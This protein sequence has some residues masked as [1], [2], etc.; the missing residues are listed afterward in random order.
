MLLGLLV[1]GSAAAASAQELNWAQKLFE[2]QRHDF[3]VVARGADVV[4]PLKL[5]NSYQQTVHIANVRTSCGCI[6]ATASKDTLLSGDSAT[7]QVRVD[8]RRFS[9]EKNSN[10]I[11]TFDA[12]QYQE[13]T[14]PIHAYIRT[15]VVL[16]PGGAEFGS[17]ALGAGQ[18][19]HI[20]ISYAGR[21]D[22]TIKSVIC[23]NDNLAT[24]LTEVS[25]SEG[26]V[27]YDLLVAV[28]SSA[29][30]GDIRE[31]ILLLTDDQN[32]PE[33]PVLVEARVE[34]EFII[35]PNV[36]SLG[37]LAP[38]QKKTVQVVVRGRKPFDIAKIE[39]ETGSD[40]FKV[41][42]PDR[43][44]VVHVLPL[45]VTAPKESGPLNEEF[46]VTISGNPQPV[47]FKVNGR[48]VGGSDNGLEPAPAPAPG[49]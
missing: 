2:K 40:A 30:V 13:V 20:A 4:Y 27:N 28:K 23:K 39:S 16:T 33:I 12:P 34:P 42:L 26:R 15:D 6:S 18:E 45:I 31:Q 22:W 8:T 1:L 43:P 17:V 5:N 7:I 47:H 21:P 10:V 29:S 38:G 41:R 35:T 48:I 37:S 46:T 3:G 44:N 24:R 11:V 19:R 49:S 9:R 14:I 25:R 36:V 32:S